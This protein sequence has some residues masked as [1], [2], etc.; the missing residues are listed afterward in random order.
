M[1]DAKFVIF[2]LVAVVV[3]VSRLP[4]ISTGFGVDPDAWRMV[5]AA[6]HLCHTGE[7]LINAEQLK[8][9]L[10]EGFNID[11]LEGT[12]EFNIQ[13]NGIDLLKH[14]ARIIH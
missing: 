5:D 9:L 7:Y 8:R 10:S 12:N 1:I 2:A 11:L 6:R 3:L 4:F 14:G 13:V